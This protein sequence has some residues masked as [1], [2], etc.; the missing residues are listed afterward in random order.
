MAIDHELLI[1]TFLVEAEEKC[2]ALEPL[3]LE[4][5]QHPD[6]DVR[7]ATIFRLAHT[8]KGN[9]ALVGH[10]VMADFVHQVEGVLSRVRERALQPTEEVTGLL[11]EAVDAL[12]R[13]A[14]RAIDSPARPPDDVRALSER[15]GRLGQQGP[16]GEGQATPGPAPRPPSD[17]PATATRRTL[18]VDLDELDRL[19]TLTGELAVAR[20]RLTMALAPRSAVTAGAALEVH[21]EADR[22]QL[23]LQELAMKLRLVPLGPTLR[24]QARTVRDAAAHA[25]REARLMLEGEG[26]EL[27]TSLVEFLKDPLTHLVRNAVA[28][29][30]ESPEQRLAA[31]KP[32]EGLVTV[33]ARREAQVVVVTVKDD[34]RGLDL[35]RIAATAKARGV[36]DAEYLPPRALQ[37]LIFEP[38]FSTAPHVTVVAGRG[39]GLDVVRRHVEAMRGAVTVHS[40]PGQGTTFTLRLPLSLA[41]IQGFAVTVGAD[42]FVVP[43]D[44][45]EECIELGAG[46]SAEAERG[47]F[48]LRGEALPWVELRRLFGLSGSAGRRACR[49]RGR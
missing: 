16:A 34:G 21:H 45:V 13:L 24:M 37:Q 44:D 30:L 25:G 4:L 9:A 31:G 15:L 39:V 19:L 18:R 20:G 29:G 12:R 22:L 14:P 43:M 49:R 7:L 27:D 47:V 3:L 1:K 32:L 40:V 23:E 33:S 46:P 6:D 38:G 5:E 17:G 36:P 2:E 26:I 35:P 11:L 42:E 8:L 10:Q 28:H 48:N 41:I